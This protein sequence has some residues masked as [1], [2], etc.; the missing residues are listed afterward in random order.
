MMYLVKK[1][2][3]V[4]TVCAGEVHLIFESYCSAVN[5]AQSAAEVLSRTTCIKTENG[6]AGVG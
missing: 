1:R 2:A 4:W 6:P 3:G 5:T